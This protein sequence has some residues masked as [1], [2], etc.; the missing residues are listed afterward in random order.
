MVIALSIPALAWSGCKGDPPPEPEPDPTELTVE[1]VLMNNGESIALQDEFFDSEGNHVRLLALKFYLADISLKQSDG[2]YH[3]VSEIELFDFKPLD[4]SVNTPQWERGY[5]YEVPAGDY[6]A[7]RF[8]LGVPGELNGMD[9]AGYGNEEALSIYSN[10][11]WSWASM[12]RFVILEAQ[13]DSLGGVNFDHDLI[14]HTGL[15]ELYRA[16]IEL[17]VAFNVEE[18][19]A[20]T[21]QIGIDWNTLFHN[22]EQAI[23][24]ESAHITHTT[25]NTEEFEL[26]KQFTDNFVQALHI[27]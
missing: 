18:G 3:E 22:G 27:P 8:G 16:D 6:T 13:M 17:P 10:M 1:V 7:I 21:I 14:F 4:E 24:I 15:D 26:A 9:P 11:Y 2:T 23:P 25:D 20:S 5:T 19:T 12:Y